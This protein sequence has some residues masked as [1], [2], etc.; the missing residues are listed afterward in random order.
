M[1]LA[2]A[3]A[4]GLRLPFLGRLAFPDEGG[5]LVVASRWHDDGS[6]LYGR[7]FVDRPPVLLLFFRLADLLGGLHAARLLGLA[8]VAVTVAAAA[9][10][11]HTLAGRRGL[12]VAA[13]LAAALLANPSLGTIEVNAELVGAPLTMLASSL[14]LRAATGPRRRPDGVLLL[15]AGALAATAVLVKQNL[16]DA[17]VLGLAL[18]TAYGV[19]RAWPWRR[20]AAF[21]GLLLVGALPP[22]LATAAW[23]STE[24]PGLGSLWFTLY[25][26]R[27]MATRVIVDQPSSAPEHRAWVLLGMAL[28]SGLVLVLVAAAWTLRR[29][30]RSGDPVT[31]AIVAM[32]LA[33]TAGVVGGGSYWTHYLVGL[34]PGTALLA[35]R[36]AGALSGRRT[37]ALSVALA[38]ASAVVTTGVTASAYSPSTDTQMAGL[39][40]WLRSSDRPGD[41]ATVLYGHADILA[42]TGLRPRYPYLWSLPVRTLDPR[43]HRLVRLLDSRRAPD[44]V[45]TPMSL[46]SWDL[47]P[48]QHV[49][50]ALDRH[51]RPVGEVC[52]IPVYLH[53]GVRRPLAALPTGCQP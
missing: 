43:L 14:L 34:V 33:E 47:D 19:T 29:G 53:D 8:L 27:V 17:L 10:A 15:G 41:T 31:L 6:T 30:L 1:L 20:S 48:H 2:I 26:F 3:M 38:A 22:V 39:T 16:A 12:T 46:T 52:G 7:L 21:A 5:L 24:T 40:G 50:A 49:Q 25:D 42:D 23:A 11:G 18:A 28:V 32:V 37:V 35:A 4:V 51:Y 45:L 13:L 9:W 36:A 44:W